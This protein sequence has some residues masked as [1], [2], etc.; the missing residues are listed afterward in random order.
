MLTKIEIKH[1]EYD[2]WST[3]FGVRHLKCKGQVRVKLGLTKTRL[4][5]YDIWSTTFR[6]LHL[7][8]KDQVRVK[9]GLV[10]TRHLKYD[11]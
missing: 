10:K 8:C 3:A 4:L 1:F 5:K 7:K 11:I 6:V 2:I 9:L